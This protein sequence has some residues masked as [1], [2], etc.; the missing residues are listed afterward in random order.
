MAEDLKNVRL[1]QSATEIADKIME[2]ELFDDKIS[3]AKFALA[4]TVKYHIDGLDPDL[5]DATYDSNGSNYNIGSIDEDKF[6]SGLIQAIYPNTT[7]PYR[8]IR[9]LMI[10]GLERL[11]ELLAEGRLYP[12]NQWL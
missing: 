8:Y 11:G 12:L 3:V 1:S 5:L 10:Y 6:L 7:T 9:V 4:Y 2:S